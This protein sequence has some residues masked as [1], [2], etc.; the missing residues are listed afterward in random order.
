[1]QTPLSRF[2]FLLLEGSLKE[3]PIWL[4]DFLQISFVFLICRTQIDSVARIQ[5]ARLSGCLAGLVFQVEKQPDI[6]LK[7]ELS[8]N[9]ASLMLGGQT[10]LAMGPAR[11]LAV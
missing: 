10:F 8:G 1:M 7:P 5:Q 11:Y 4:L 2:M 6:W 9:E 3:G